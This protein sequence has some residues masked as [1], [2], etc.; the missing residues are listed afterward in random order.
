MHL[1]LV[2]L[3]WYNPRHEDEKASFVSSAEIRCR[4]RSADCL[5][6]VEVKAE[7]NRAKSLRTMIDRDAYKDIRWGVKLVNGNVGYENRVLTLPQWCAF[8][9]PRIVREF[10]PERLP[11]RD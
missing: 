9:L 7:N 6:P 3:I 11:S 5:I 4:L 1:H 10:D 8:L 2:S